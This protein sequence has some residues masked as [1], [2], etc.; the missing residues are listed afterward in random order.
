M[1]IL[2]GSYHWADETCFCH[3]VQ[4]TLTSI[5]LSMKDHSLRIFSEVEG[6]VNLAVTCKADSEVGSLEYQSGQS[7]K[8]RYWKFSAKNWEK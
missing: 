5:W 3:K 6:V 8:W 2:I 4:L 1:K 7:I